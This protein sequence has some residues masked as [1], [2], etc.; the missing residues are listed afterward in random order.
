MLGG[1]RLRSIRFGFELNVNLGRRCARSGM[2]HAWEL[3]E[4]TGHETR[5]ALVAQTT[6]AEI[7]MRVAA[8]QLEP[9]RLRERLQPLERKPVRVE[10]DAQSRPAVR[11]IDVNTGNACAPLKHRAQTFDARVEVASS[12]R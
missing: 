6:H 10:V 7:Q 12:R 1:E 4:A 5:A 11:S 3:L 8:R 2:E 9:R